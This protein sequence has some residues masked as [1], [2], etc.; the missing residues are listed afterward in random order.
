PGPE[1][2]RAR[3]EAGRLRDPDDRQPAPALVVP[4]SEAPPLA[5]AASP[6]AP[7]AAPA[8][9]HAAP[10][11]RAAR[12]GRAREGPRRDARLRPVHVPRPA[13]ARLAAPRG[14]PPGDGRRRHGRPARV[15]A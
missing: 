8:T 3:A 5:R 9:A 10:G 14:A 1:G 15:G 4:R 6:R 11:G 7:A 2:A 13:H 12:A